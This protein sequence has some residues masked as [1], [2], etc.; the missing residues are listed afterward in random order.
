MKV[1]CRL[2]DGKPA[3]YEADVEVEDFDYTLA[4]AK[5]LGALGL[6]ET[7]SVVIFRIK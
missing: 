6:T 7:T 4:K 5:V 2:K 1:I 3:T